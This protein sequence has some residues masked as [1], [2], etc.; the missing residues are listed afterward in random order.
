MYFEKLLSVRVTPRAVERVRSVAEA[1]NTSAADVWRA[2][3]DGLNTSEPLPALVRPTTDE[4]KQVVVR[5][6][7]AQYRKFML[8]RAVNACSAVELFESIEPA[9]AMSTEVVA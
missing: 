4:R 3:L 8:A 7:A 1:H 5:V 6:S 9:A 2:V